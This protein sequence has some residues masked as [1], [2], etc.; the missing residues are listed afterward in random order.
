M[1]ADDEQLHLDLVR[2]EHLAYQSKELNEALLKLFQ[3]YDIDESGTVS[4]TEFVRLEIRHGLETGD[5]HRVFEAFPQVSCSDRKRDGMLRYSDFCKSRLRWLDSEQRTRKLKR[6]PTG[7]ELAALA[8]GEAKRTIE[9][10]ARMGCRYH[11]AVRKE[12]N[13]IFEHW[14]LFRGKGLS[15]VEW[16]VARAYVKAKVGIPASLNW[17]SE[18][19]F[20]AADLKKDLSVQLDGFLNASFSFLE[21]TYPNDASTAALMLRQ[22]K[23][24]VESQ[25]RVATIKVLQADVYVPKA[26]KPEFQ[27]PSRCK[28][29]MQAYEIV[30][31]FKLP[32]DLTLLEDLLSILRLLLRIPSSKGLAIFCQHEEELTRLTDSNIKGQVERMALANSSPALFVKNIR[33]Q[34]ERLR[35]EPPRREEECLP[36]LSSI[37]GMRWALDWE[38]Q[39][40]G[41]GLRTP[42]KL[43]FD[44]T[45]GLGDALVIRIPATDAGMTTQVYMDTPGVLSYPV[46]QF[47]KKV[48]R[49]ASS[50]RT[51]KLQKAEAEAGELKPQAPAG[52]APSKRGR[53]TKPSGAKLARSP[54]ARAANEDQ[55]LVFVPLSEGSCTLFVEISWEHREQECLKANAY[56]PCAESSVTRIGP[57]KVP[58]H[59]QSKHLNG[60]SWWNG[61]R[62]TGK[63]LSKKGRGTSLGGPPSRPQSASPQRPRPASARS[64]PQSARPR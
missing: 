4:S 34:P 15:P 63:Q 8:L 7:E 58:V 53:R 31:D 28:H 37:T 49:S 42:P 59:R 2:S 35:L 11:L 50:K 10:R 18:D 51:L 22:L 60:T 25:R 43:P 6:V 48:G 62:W 54:A 29:D 13:D 26:Q 33:P 47:V 1:E 24:F 30:T 32:T 45:L 52:P 44:M 16:V 5:L 9:E 14:R 64:R 56:G 3:A 20:V 39:T 57:L 41:K 27:L 38:V 21:E 23:H 12:L 19:N 40:L 17:L 61:L 46:V 55:L 36:L